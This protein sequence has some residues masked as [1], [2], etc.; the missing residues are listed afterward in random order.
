MPATKPNTFRL[1]LNEADT[2]LM[3]EV[4]EK[5]EMGQ[6]ELMSKLLAAALRAVA[7]NGHRF[8]IP[9]RFR[10]ADLPQDPDRLPRSR[11]THKP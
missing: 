9:L 2:A 5:T 3:R 10:V 8:V 7:D 6:S 11:L 1:Y 4:C